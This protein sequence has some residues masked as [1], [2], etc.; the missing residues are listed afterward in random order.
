MSAVNTAR[1]H[2]GRLRG[3][4]ELWQRRNSADETAFDSYFTTPSGHTGVTFLASTGDNGSPGGYPAYS[5]NVVAVG[6]TTLTLSGNNYSSETGWSGSG[7]GQSTVE[8]EP[9]FQNGVQTSGMRQTP[10]VA[11]LADRTPDPT[12]V[13]VY[14]SYEAGS[15]NAWIRGRRHQ[16]LGALLGRLDRHCRSTARRCERRDPGWEHA[17]PGRPLRAAHKRF[18]RHYQRQQRRLLGRPRLRH[19]DGHRQSRGQPARA[20][21]GAHRRRPEAS[22]CKATV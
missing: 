20:R 7:G 3:F 9:I 15:S 12:G 8:T 19:G 6:G 14:D 21:L 13:A 18:P 5:P 10:D 4:H 17:D 16:P 22:T 1:N 11:L 2:R